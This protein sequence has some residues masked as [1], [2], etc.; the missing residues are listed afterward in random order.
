MTILLALV[1][2][3]AGT[4][5]G[6]LA[7][8]FMSASAQEAKELADQATKT[9]SELAQYKQDVAEHLDSSTQLLE[10]MNQACQKAMTQM[11]ESTK[12]L[13]RATPSEDEIEAMPFFSKETQEQLAQT[14]SLR[15]KKEERAEPVDATAAPLD[16]SEGSSGLFNDSKQ[17][18]TN[19]ETTN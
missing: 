10:Q 8:K 16:Y 18:V 14:V 19:P 7:N 15:H 1:L 17:P 4:V 12:L 6:F 2:F 11:E 9:E 5:V 13:Q 3:A